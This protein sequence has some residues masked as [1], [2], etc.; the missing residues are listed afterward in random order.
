M[1][2]PP[3]CGCCS[4]SNVKAVTIKAIDKSDG[5]TVWEY[6]P[7]AFWRHH[8]DADEISGVVPNL[9]A[10]LDRYA[11]SA[12]EYP[13]FAPC[14]NRNTGT[15]EANAAEALSLV[16]LD[17]LDGSVIESTT[18]TGF[19]CD[20]IAESFVG[21]MSGLSITNAAA[22][23]GGDFVI[24]GERLP[25]I[26]FD[27]F[28]TNA[29]TKTYTLH[30]HGQRAGSVY[31]TTRTSA[32]TIEIPFDSTAAEV[33]ALFEAATD[34]VTATATGGPWPL[35]PIVVEVEWSASSGDVSGI[36]ATGTYT[37]EG[38]GIEVE[39]TNVFQPGDGTYLFT[40]TVTSVPVGSIWK[41]QFD[42]SGPHAPS[43][44][45]E[46]EAT[47]DNINSFIDAFTA[48]FDAF[49]AANSS[50][51]NFATIVLIQEIDNVFSVEYGADSINLI[52][53][54][55]GGA[56]NE[57]TRPAGSC[58]ASYDTGS[59]GMLS[60]VGFEFGYSA[61]RPPLRMFD[62]GQEN[63]AVT[64]L[65]V[66]GIRSIG[67]GPSNSVV[68][69]PLERGLG[70]ITKANVLEHW[71]ISGGTWSFNWQTFGNPKLILPRII[72][73]ESGHMVCPIENTDFGSGYTSA[74]IV[75]LIDGTAV[76]FHCDQ[77]STSAANN[78]SSSLA[79]LYDESTTDVL[80][81][82]FDVTFEQIN[83]R[84][85]FD[86][87]GVDTDCNGAA[88]LLGGVAF[89]CDGT[90]V[91]ANAGGTG[92]VRT[93][94]PTGFTVSGLAAQ[95]RWR[96][97][98]QSGVRHG[99]TTQ[100]RIVFTPAVGTNVPI[101]RTAWLNWDASASEIATAILDEFG[102]NTAGGASNVTVWPFGEP[103]FSEN[104]YI[105]QVEKNLDILL[106]TAND[107]GG[108]GSNFIPSAYIGLGAFP[109]IELQNTESFTNPAGI[110]AFDASDASLIWS[111]PF[112][113]RDGVVQGTEYAWLN[114]GFVYAYGS[115]VDAEL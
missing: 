57:D 61:E 109:T 78:D 63:P 113:S 79:L 6:G 3:L 16:K 27:D 5:T 82:G 97:Y 81:F 9:A 75:D 58:A 26:E 22:L 49:R 30:A 42:G 37:V 34:C 38:A 43:P 102:E 55:E 84:F 19:F 15:L 25:F 23:S 4:P 101:V 93:R 86:A 41:L 107:S 44:I 64:G 48:A 88:L 20:T 73:V 24:V 100:F 89:G 74:G 40:M 53:V 87:F 36:S 108:L 99:G 2:R 50:E 105:S 94:R 54:L 35:V 95:W 70:D 52:L 13:S 77:V 59:G 10:T 104:A 11:I 69:C 103:M 51:E 112:G 85:R 31:L 115:L 96:F 72:A 65:S 83:T 21:L 114:G 92:A 68:I 17:S 47:T 28:S 14:G 111:R 56:A 1:K 45:F 76:P 106:L 110:A 39:T 80:T 90:Q 12:R 67:S 60:A 8:Y 46:Y 98:L 91:Y 29:A 71:S 18:L 62:D 7:G 32:E 33:E 66:L